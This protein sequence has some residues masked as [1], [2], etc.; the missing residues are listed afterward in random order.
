VAQCAYAKSACF[1]LETGWD[2]STS[3]DTSGHPMTLPTELRRIIETWPSLPRHI[4]RAITALVES[5]F[6]ALR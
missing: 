6:E 3:G 4:V 5:A 1:W 2:P